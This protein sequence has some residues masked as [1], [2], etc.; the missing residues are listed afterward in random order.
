MGFLPTLGYEERAG[1]GGGIRDRNVNNAAESPPDFSVGDT[2]NK[3]TGVGRPCLPLISLSHNLKAFHA[4]PRQRRGQHFWAD[5]NQQDRQVGTSG[6]TSCPL[7]TASLSVSWFAW[8]FFGRGF[9]TLARLS[10]VFRLL[11]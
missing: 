10:V 4:L 6:S 9:P 3:T 5:T 1:S 7:F 11:T 2:G 8:Q